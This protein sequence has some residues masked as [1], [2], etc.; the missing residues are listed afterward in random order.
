VQRDDKMDTSVLSKGNV[1]VSAA[2]FVL[3]ACIALRR[4]LTT[5]LLGGISVTAFCFAWYWGVVF[6][7]TELLWFIT[8]ALLF[9]FTFIGGCIFIESFAEELLSERLELSYK[10][11]CAGVAIGLAQVLIAFVLRENV[12]WCCVLNFSLDLA[13]VGFNFY[14]ALKRLFRYYRSGR[15]KKKE[16]AQRTNRR[17]TRNVASVTKQNLL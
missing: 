12:Y 17:R 7:L 15:R 10:T 9:I 2:S 3:H 11:V 16:I 8:G 1:G 13:G 5:L 4:I 6:I 14:W